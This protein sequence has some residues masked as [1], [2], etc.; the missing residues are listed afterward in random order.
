MRP[1]R[2]NAEL[3]PPAETIFAFLHFRMI[4]RVMRFNTTPTSNDPVLAVDQI[5]NTPTHRRYDFPQV[6]KSN[7]RVLNSRVGL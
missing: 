5:N 3:S 1:G 7:E 6:S 4:H 2:S